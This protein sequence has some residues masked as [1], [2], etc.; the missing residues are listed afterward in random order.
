MK[1]LMLGSSGKL[2]L[3][4]NIDWSYGESLTTAVPFRIIVQIRAAT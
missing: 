4:F 3:D 2:Q 1:S